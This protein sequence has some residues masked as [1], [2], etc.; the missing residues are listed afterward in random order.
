[1]TEMPEWS[2]VLHRSSLIYD[3]VDSGW[4]SEN[5]KASFYEANKSMCDRL[6][7]EWA[8]WR[9]RAEKLTGDERLKALGEAAIRNGILQSFGA[10]HSGSTIW[11]PDRIRALSRGTHDNYHVPAAGLKSSA[12]FWIECAEAM[13]KLEKAQIEAWRKAGWTGTAPWEKEQDK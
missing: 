8:E 5:Y 7:A 12:D 1:M 9:A 6:E 11:K 10:F 4:R 2:P 3:W 13:E